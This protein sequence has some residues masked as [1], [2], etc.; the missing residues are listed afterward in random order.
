MQYLGYTYTEKKFVICLKFQFNWT[1]CIFSGKP[2]PQPIPA[3]G[4]L[5]HEQKVPPEVSRNSRETPSGKVSWVMPGVERRTSAL[6]ESCREQDLPESKPSL[7]EACTQDE[8][9]DSGR[10]KPEQPKGEPHRS[11]TSQPK[12]LIGVCMQVLN[13]P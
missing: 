1:F 6:G 13:K 5:G 11:K 7:T 9:S 4:T 12:Y 3:F 10:K 8:Y 2:S